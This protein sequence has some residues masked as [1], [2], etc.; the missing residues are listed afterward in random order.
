MGLESATEPLTSFQELVPGL[1]Q[2]PEYART[3]IRSVHPREPESEI[4][5]RVEMRMHR[6][7]LI[8]RRAQ[9]A[10]LDVILDESA[11]HRVIG[12]PKIM[13]EHHDP[14]PAVRGGH[15][16]RRSDRAVHNLGLR[17][18]RPPTR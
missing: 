9:P 4:D 5:R 13:A 15:S 17:R 7:V 3:L 8:T 14:R 10:A 12:S 2:I 11:L 16:S 6:Q 1:A 18:R